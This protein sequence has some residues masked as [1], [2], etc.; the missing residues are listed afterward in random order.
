M[1]LKYE[2]LGSVWYTPFM[3][4]SVNLDMCI[5]IVAIRSGKGDDW[6]CYIGYGFGEDEDYDAQ[7]VA[8]QGIPVA[9]EAMACALF[10]DLKPEGYKQ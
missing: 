9:N 8:G 1:S 6:K 5:G 4:P 10:P 7:L 2:I 3:L